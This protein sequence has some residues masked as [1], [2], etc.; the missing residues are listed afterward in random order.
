MAIIT[1][2]RGSYSKGKDVAR[3]V[4]EKLGYRCIAREVLLDASR[5]FNVPEIRLVRAIHDAPSILERF[6]HGKEK[7]IA[8]FRAAMLKQ[9]VPDNVVYHGLAGHFFV[10]GISHA[11]KVRIIADMND[12]VR[13]EMERMRLPREEALRIL[14][15]DDEERRKWSQDLYGIDTADPSLYDLVVHIRKITVEDAAD[16]ICQVVGLERFRTAP[17]SQ[18][19]IEDMALAAEVKAA[20]L[21]VKHDVEVHAAS[22]F[23]RLETRVPLE[24]QKELIAEMERITKAIPGVKGLDIKA[25]QK[26][27]LSDG[28]LFP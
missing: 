8:S 24:E 23:V 16:M 7:Y 22:G 21:D 17:E 14:K 20:L 4:A 28:R 5:D 12:R 11:L 9:F 18:R 2:S 3:L 6:T 25:V 13:T 27:K 19:A 26:V 1:I 10:K 15:S